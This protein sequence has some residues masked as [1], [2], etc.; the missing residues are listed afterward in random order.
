MGMTRFHHISLAGIVL[1][2]PACGIFEN[3]NP[4]ISSAAYGGVAGTAIGAGAGA[5]VGSAMVD[6]DVAMSALAGSGIGLAAGIVMG[7][8]YEEF[9]YQAAYQD[10][11]FE[12]D[13]NKDRLDEQQRQ[14]EDLRATLKA[15]SDRINPDEDNTEVIYDG[16]TLGNFHR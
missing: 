7:I 13:S 8:G 12:I 16:A 10:N 9:K 14:I 6:G 2:L 15:E 4:K 1:L 5:A 11:E 3:P